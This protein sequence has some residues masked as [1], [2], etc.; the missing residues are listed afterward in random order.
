MMEQI[1]LILMLKALLIQIHLEALIWVAIA[2][3]TITNH[4]VKTKSLICQQRINLPS[5][6][7]FYP[8]IRKNSI[9]SSKISKKISLIC[10]AEYLPPVFDI[11]SLYYFN[12][13]K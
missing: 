6:N 3:S 13:I 5:S 9:S 4:L 12:K 2:N 11:P 7:T 1:M 10:S 8:T